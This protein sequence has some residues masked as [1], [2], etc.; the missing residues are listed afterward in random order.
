M[1]SLAPE[2][3]GRAAETIQSEVWPLIWPSVEAMLRGQAGKQLL[4]PL[5]RGE[6]RDAVLRSCS[7]MP[8]DEP[9]SETGVGG[10][11]ALADRNADQAVFRA[12]EQNEERLSLALAAGLIGTWDWHV[13]SNK[14]YANEGFARFYGVD[15]RAAATGAPIESFVAAMYPD[16]RERVKTQIARAVASG[17]EFCEEYRLVQADGSIRWVLARGRCF[18]AADGSPTR[19]PG[20]TIDIT[21]RKRIEQH[22]KLLAEELRHRVQNTLAMV[23]SIAMQTLTGNA[24]IETARDSFMERLAAFGRGQRALI[25]NGGTTADLGAI[26]SAT[27]ETYAFDRSRFSLGGDPISLAPLHALSLS[28]AMHELTTNAVKHGALSGPTGTVSVA[29]KI[30]AA[31]QRFTIS[32]IETNGPKVRPPS[33]TGFGTVLLQRII[34]SDFGGTARSEYAPAGFRW[35]LVAPLQ[36]T[37]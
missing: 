5:K 28:L 3:N 16:D 12:H 21:D 13:A 19:F 36:E 11:L 26:V 20:A 35:D 33:R 25:E 24:P 8:I 6:D 23:Q 7:L 29:W 15:P 2:A 32:W 27:I 18:H 30:D 31:R 37:D 14:V 22:K 9:T 1:W 17:E 34:E 4:L 10:V